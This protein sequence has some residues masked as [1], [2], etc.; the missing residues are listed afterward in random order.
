MSN[1]EAIEA[2]EE[3]IQWVKQGKQS[4]ENALEEINFIMEHSKDGK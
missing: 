4:P 1:Q 2:I 3:V